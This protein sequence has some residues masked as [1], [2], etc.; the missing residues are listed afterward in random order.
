MYVIGGWNDTEHALR[1]RLPT[2][3]D[4]IKAKKLNVL[5]R[6]SL[7]CNLDEALTEVFDKYIEEWN[8]L[9]TVGSQLFDTEFNCPLFGTFVMQYYK[10]P[11]TNNWDEHHRTFTRELVVAI[12]TFIKT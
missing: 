8:T 2:T 1:E 6:T 12:D 10:C 4:I 7:V 11:K 3:I 9:N 5:G